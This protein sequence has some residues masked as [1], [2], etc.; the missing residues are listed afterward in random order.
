MEIKIIQN[1]L[2]EEV[3]QRMN[4]WTLDNYKKNFFNISEMNNCKTRYTTRQCTNRGVDNLFD[5]PQYVY[6]IQNKICK[7][8]NIYD[9][10]KAFIGKN[11][12]VTGIGFENDYIEEHVDPIWK[13]NT[14]SI[15]FNFI[16]KK[17]L[18]GGI[19]IINEKKYET[20]PGDLLIYNVSK[21]NHSVSKVEGNIPRILYVFGFSL[22]YK[23]I[24]SIFYPQKNI[25]YS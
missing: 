5:Y 13:K 10:S 3:I 6:D 18:F 24:K 15:H 21:Y 7:D 14:Q 17:P 25:C 12:I 16:T 19:T 9:Q 20:N 11:G 22:N 4:E 2:S 8:F 1:Y 23:K